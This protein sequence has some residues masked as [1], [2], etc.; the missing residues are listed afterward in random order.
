M[1]AVIS[2]PSVATEISHIRRQTIRLF[3]LQFFTNVILIASFLGMSCGC[4]ASR[5]QQDWLSYFPLIALGTVVAA[6]ATSTAYHFWSG[7]VID[8]GSQRSA[9]EV[10]FGTEY[11]NPDVA[12]FIVPIEA[13]AAVF[14]V[15]VALMFVGLGQVM[16]RAFDTYPN[17]V[18]GYTL[19]IGGSLTGIAAFSAL[20]FLEAPPAIWFLIC[21]AGIAYLLHQDGALDWTR[22]IAGLMLL[23][24]STWCHFHPAARHIR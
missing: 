24:I 16:G 10:F 2:V 7:L 5:R 8:V 21:C 12:Q 19:N 4:L 23:A 20:A 9:Q 6:L 15:L 17:R 18:L 3:S 14:F 11:A 13:I 22:A 1:T